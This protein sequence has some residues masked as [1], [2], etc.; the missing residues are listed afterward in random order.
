MVD[1]LVVIFIVADVSSCFFCRQ[2]ISTATRR[3]VVIR[4]V[5][6][7]HAQLLL[8]VKVRKVEHEDAVYMQHRDFT[9]NICEWVMKKMVDAGDIQCLGSIAAAFRDLLHGTGVKVEWKSSLFRNGHLD[10]GNFPSC[11]RVLTYCPGNIINRD[12]YLLFRV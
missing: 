7:S 1:F 12:I 9:L 10:V 6:V 2:S 8:Q 4:V 5:I 11:P 3:Y